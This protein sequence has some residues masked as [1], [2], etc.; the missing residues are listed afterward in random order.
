MFSL[1]W[2]FVLLDVSSLRR[3]KDQLPDHVEYWQIK[4]C[5]SLLMVTTGFVRPSKQEPCLQLLSPTLN[6]TPPLT[7]SSTMSQVSVLYLMCKRIYVK[8]MCRKILT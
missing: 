8:F 1:G 3:I 2:L 7:Q 4:M 5:V 6:M